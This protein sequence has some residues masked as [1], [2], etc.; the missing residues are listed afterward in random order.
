VALHQLSALYRSSWG[1]PLRLPS[2]L[3]CLPST[4]ELKARKAADRRRDV[5]L[6]FY[7]HLLSPTSFQRHF[8][9][10][11]S[12][13][14]N[15]YYGLEHR[16]F[17]FSV[18][19]NGE[20]LPKTTVRAWDKWSSLNSGRRAGP[21]L[22]YQLWPSPP[23]EPADVPH[24]RSGIF[25][26][27]FSRDKAPQPGPR[28]LEKPVTSLN[29]APRQPQLEFDRP[30]IMQ[31]WNRCSLGTIND[32]PATWDIKS[33]TEFRTWRR[34]DRCRNQS[35]HE[36]FRQQ[37]ELTPW[38]SIDDLRADLNRQ[39]PFWKLLTEVANTQP[40]FVQ[41]IEDA[42]EDY[43]SF[44]GLFHGNMVRRLQY[45]SKFHPKLPLPKSST[46]AP[47]SRFIAL[48]P[49]TLEVDLLWH[50]HRMFPSKYWIWSSYQA[51]WLIEHQTMNNGAAA[52]ALSKTKQE[53]ERRL[54][55]SCPTKN[56]LRQ[57]LDRYVPDAARYAREDCEP[58][59]LALMMFGYH[60]F[61]GRKYNPYRDKWDS[62]GTTGG[63]GSGGGGAVS[64]D[65]GCGGDGGGGGGE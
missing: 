30:I 26:S 1:S 50:T 65:G 11:R 18:L 15:L 61:K 35:Q 5:A 38:P 54:G 13:A 31:D 33:Y 9:N 60:P 40:L 44:I 8:W 4:G 45:I 2:P 25:S 12:W 28:K 14:N 63:G 6:I 51:G 29:G 56:D 10:S 32:L 23:W 41:G 24:R 42:I 39:I 16:H 21:N 27:I 3:V 47:G 43:A 49:P 17:P 46:T 62:S 64:S 20:W 19:A 48:A 53:W 36:S 34:F 22:T 57:W 7:L 52:Y 55:T 58:G 59:D 37:C